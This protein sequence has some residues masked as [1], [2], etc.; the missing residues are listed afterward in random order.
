MKE[1]KAYLHSNRVAAVIAA[2]KGSPAWSAGANGRGHN[3]TLYAVK[4][5]L[6]PLHEAERRYSIE[7]G[8]EVVNEYKLELHCDD[9]QVDEFI[10]VIA[11]AGRTGQ[12]GAGWIYVT[13]VHRAEPIV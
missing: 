11:A 6:A 8:D 3:L 13:E 7:L 12:P 4:G 10:S 9:D 1:I 5:S 2:L